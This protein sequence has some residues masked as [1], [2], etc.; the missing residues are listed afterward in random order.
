MSPSNQDNISREV[1]EVKRTIDRLVLILLCLV[2]SC[3]QNDGREESES[4]L[5][6]SVIKDPPN[7]IE[8]VYIPAGSFIMGSSNADDEKPAH[9]VR[10]DG[11]YIGKFVITQREWTAVMGDNPSEFVGEEHPV[12]N[13]SWDDAQLFVGRLSENT[14]KRYRLPTEAEWEY[15]ARAGSTTNFH[16]GND[17]SE[18]SEYA[19]YG[20]DSLGTTQPVGLKK[21]NAWGLYDMAGNVR[22]WCQDWWDPGYYQRSDYENPINDEEY[23]YRNPRTNEE[24]GVRVAR[25]GSFRDAPSG[26]E[27]A[28]RHGARPFASHYIL[29]F[30]VVR[31][32]LP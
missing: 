17:T 25:S 10:L 28:H 32:V 14:G 22:E 19:W 16:F 3:S 29:G 8:M 7:N 24:Y 21:P 30:R 11:F 26:S 4:G 23:F 18:L 13:V 20:A 1:E 2:L 12:E 6:G 9:E 5:A 31:E 27:S 15:A